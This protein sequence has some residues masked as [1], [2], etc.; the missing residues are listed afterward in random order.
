MVAMLIL[1]MTVILSLRAI[2]QADHVAKVAEDVRQANVLLN[3]LLDNGPRSFQVSQGESD[4]FRWTVETQA[5]GSD[6]P[7]AVCRRVVALTNSETLRRYSE[8]TFE[9]CPPQDAP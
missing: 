6:R 8:T 4:R 9:T 7:V 1:A 5:T 3:E 2:Q